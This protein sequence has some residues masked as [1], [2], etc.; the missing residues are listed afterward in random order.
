MLTLSGGQPAA[1]Q[2]LQKRHNILNLL[3]GQI[4]IFDNTQ[5]FSRPLKTS[6]L[7]S[8]QLSSGHNPHNVMQIIYRTI[9]KPGTGQRHIT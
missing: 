5:F 9:M 7:A 6:L 8:C 1:T 4:R 2:C 3:I